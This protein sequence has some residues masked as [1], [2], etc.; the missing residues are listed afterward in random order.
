MKLTYS[1]NNGKTFDSFDEAKNYEIEEIESEL[2]Q[3]L[4]NTITGRVIAGSVIG[5]KL[6]IHQILLENAPQIQKILSEY[7]ATSNTKIEDL[8]PDDLH[9][10][11]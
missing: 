5:L 6:N 10:S 2:G 9:D 11:Y 4:D 1:S 7:I 8:H 3:I